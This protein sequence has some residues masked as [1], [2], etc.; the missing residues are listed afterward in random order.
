MLS[1]HAP[2]QADADAVFHVLSEIGAIGQLATAVLTRCL[3]EGMHPSHFAVV[4]HLYRM[5]DGMTPAGI[6]A[7]THVT[8]TTMSHTL[9]VLE[10]RGYLTIGPSPKDGRAKTVS[11]T[12]KGRMFRTE[13]IH[14]MERRLHDQ[15]STDQLAVLADM[16]DELKSLRGH[17]EHRG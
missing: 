15:L 14:R 3:P 8:R 17:L 9:S 4:N 12:A 1:E 11:L 13:A 2:R 7:A 10:S 5:G 16:E 6:A